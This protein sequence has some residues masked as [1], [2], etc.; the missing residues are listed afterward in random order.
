MSTSETPS[1]EEDTP[2][3]AAPEP[4]AGGRQLAGKGET[5]DL[6]E[7]SILTKVCSKCSV[8]TETAGNFCPNCGASYLG[9]KAGL[10]VSKRT[11][12][13]ATSVVV[14]LMVGVVIG[15]SILQSNRDNELEQL[16]AASFAA[17]SAEASKSEAT[18]AAEASK[19][20]A[21]AAA[22]ASESAAAAKRQADK[23]ALETEMR[24]VMITALEES[25]LKDAQKRE[26]EGSL[27]GP[28]SRSSCTQLSGGSIGDLTAET[29]TFECIAVNKKND[30]GTESGYVFS[31]TMNWDTA[32]Y[33]WHLGR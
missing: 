30:D 22:V 33:Q 27:E 16:A 19:S 17:A 28:F 26:T 9:A 11:W 20:A 1:P 25:V 15:M 23:D 32:E 3:V 10:N 13:I 24:K 12:I 31:A 5:L 2:R 14:L 8:Q 18:A 21:A 6:D 7:N 29:S 4:V